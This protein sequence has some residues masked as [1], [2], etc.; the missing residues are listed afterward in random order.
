M[1][2]IF[3]KFTI[4][5]IYRF[6]RAKTTYIALRLLISFVHKA[7]FITTM[8]NVKFTPQSTNVKVLQYTK[9]NQVMALKM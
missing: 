6:N 9:E 8:Y 1:L 3:E 4:I 2:I 5:E 7:D